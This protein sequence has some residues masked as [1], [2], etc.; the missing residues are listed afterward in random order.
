MPRQESILK[1]LET[2]KSANTHLRQ[3]KR[4]LEDELQ[5]SAQEL[6]EVKARIQDYDLISREEC[7]SN[8]E[9]PSSQIHPDDKDF[10]E[11][12]FFNLNRPACMVNT[13][14]PYM[15]KGKIQKEMCQQ[16]KKTKPSDWPWNLQIDLCSYISLTKC[17][18]FGHMFGFSD[19]EAPQLSWSDLIMLDFALSAHPDLINVVEL[20][21]GTG[22]TTMYL[23]L[24]SNYRGGRLITF[25]SEQFLPTYVNETWFENMKF[26]R[27][28][29]FKK[30]FD[31]RLIQA[32]KQENT[33]YLFDNGY[34]IDEINWFLPYLSDE[35]VMCTHDWGHEVVLEFIDIGLA[36]NDWVPWAFEHAEMLGSRVRCFKKRTQDQRM[37]RVN[38]K[39]HKRNVAH[40]I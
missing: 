30:P 19:E 12:N 9:C 39:K 5:K 20:G 29:I 26:I 8:E 31:S 13:P 4:L 11:N 15:P 2:L 16:C 18:N 6:D 40:K 38:D 27:T 1:E 3:Q 7:P 25:D 35:N 14:V 23:G 37:R 24:I 33:F 28:D 10:D 22:L 36:A 17:C 21:T 34:K 32:L